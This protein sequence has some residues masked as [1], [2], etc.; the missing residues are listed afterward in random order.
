M[1]NEIPYT[2]SVFEQPW[3]LDIVAHDSWEEII[4]NDEKGGVDARF[5]YVTDGKRIYMPEKTQNLGIWM[6]EK[7]LKEYKTQKDIINKIFMQLDKYKYV[8]H[9]LNPQNQYV[10]PFRWLGYSFHTG[11]TYRIEELSDIERVKANFSKSTKRNINYAAKR[12]DVISEV[13]ISSAI[14]TMWDLLVKTYAVQK[15]KYPVSREFTEKYMRAAIENERGKYFEARDKE[16]NVHSCAFF[17]FDSRV[18]YYLTGARDP[19]YSSSQSQELLLWE[20]IQFAA[21]HSKIFDFEGSMVEGIEN[22]FRQFG[23]TS[24]P[25]YILRKQSVLNDIKD[26]IKPRIKKLA[27]YK[28]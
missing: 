12:V 18:C 19:E 21:H 25:Y 23:G 2:N 4:I 26:V 27:G 24:T 13:D 10:L 28:I 15:R 9:V 17:L 20:G 6:S 11:F 16:G 14:E 7:V 5:V 1:M 8:T 3:W 22:F